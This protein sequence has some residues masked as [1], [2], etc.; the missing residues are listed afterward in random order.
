VL[1]ILTLPLSLLWIIAAV[2]LPDSY[3]NI[4]FGERKIEKYLKLI[5]V[6]YNDKFTKAQLV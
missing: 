3:H 5:K 4:C 6:N 1:A 2:I